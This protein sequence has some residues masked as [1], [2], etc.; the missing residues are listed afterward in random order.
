MSKEKGTA[1][2]EAQLLFDLKSA[3][4]EINKLSDG[5]NIDESLRKEKDEA[6][7]EIQAL[8][9][10]QAPLVRDVKLQHAILGALRNLA[11][12]PAYIISH[13]IANSQPPPKANPLTAAIIGFLVF[14]TS[15]QKL[16]KFS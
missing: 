11:V 9:D 3:M 12:S 13:I 8:K 5:K 15:P 7:R 16:R 10:H 2:R 6:V 4:D 14:A 1:K